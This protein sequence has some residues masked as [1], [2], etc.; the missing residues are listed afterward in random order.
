MTRPSDADC[1]IQHATCVAWAGRAVVITGASGA[2]KSALAL[3][4][5]AYG[6]GLVADDRTCLWLGAGADQGRVM[7]DAPDT[8]RGRVE[9]RHLGILNADAL[10][11]TPVAAY[12][13]MDRLETDR[14]PQ[15]RMTTVLGQDIPLIYRLDGPHFAAGVMQL[16]KAGRW[17]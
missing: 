8:L 12:I 1:L 2:G 7:A 5:M 16:M 6:A 17:A 13:D 10:G 11:P 15:Q 4:L 14:L 3:L 9:A